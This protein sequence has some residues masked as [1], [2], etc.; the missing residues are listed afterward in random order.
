MRLV[1]ELEFSVTFLIMSIPGLVLVGLV[2]LFTGDLPIWLRMVIA[3]VL[4]VL[5]TIAILLKLAKR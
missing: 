1:N 4:W 2:F 5:V 3:L